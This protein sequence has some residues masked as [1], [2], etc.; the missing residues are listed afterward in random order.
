MNKTLLFLI[1]MSLLLSMVN[2]EFR[3]TSDVFVGT[4]NSTS[5]RVTTVGT[6][7]LDNEFDSSLTSSDINFLTALAEYDVQDLNFTSWQNIAFVTVNCS[8]IDAHFNTDG[9]FTHQNISLFHSQ[10]YTT[11]NTPSS[12]NI[13]VAFL[14][15]G[16]T[17]QCLFQSVYKTNVNISIDYPYSEQFIT[18]T[19]K[20][21]FV[22][23]QIA[24]LEQEQL[25]NALELQTEN[26][27]KITEY[28][29]FI[30]RSVFELWLILFFLVKIAL[31]Y[32]AFILAIAA[33]VFPVYLLIRFRQKVRVWLNLDKEV[34]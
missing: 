3:Y 17:F 32:V 28:I 12:D 5:S 20:D 4:H 33:I 10:L 27:N 15:T 11:A 9:Q 25:E 21:S 2:A 14:G 1:M 13:A 8:L 19:F 6:I 23:T 26:T 34:K 31:L 7:I 16:D 22:D 30:I 24:F 29:T 18:P